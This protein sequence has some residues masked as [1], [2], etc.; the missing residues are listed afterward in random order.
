MPHSTLIDLP[1]KITSR[2]HLQLFL[3]EGQ[4]VRVTHIREPEDAQANRVLLRIVQYLQRTR[5]L[6]AFSKSDE[7]SQDK[8]E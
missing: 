6:D 4:H 8:F 1:G 5:Y 7:S 3:G 2:Q